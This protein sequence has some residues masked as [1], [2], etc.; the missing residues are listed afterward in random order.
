SRCCGEDEH[1]SAGRHE[2]IECRVELRNRVMV[3][4]VQNHR[5]ETTDRGHPER[6]QCCRLLGGGIRKEP[7]R[8][9]LRR[10]Q[11]QRRHLG[12]NAVS[13]QLGPP[14]GNLAYAP[15]DGRSSNFRAHANVLSW[16]TTRSASGSATVIEV[17]S[18]F[19]DSMTACAT[20]V[21]R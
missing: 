13:G 18:E 7:V 8:T 12:E 15:R 14:S 2:S 19:I 9:E 11:P 6:G 10:G 16:R 1:T 3:G 20:A 17:P 5:N 4:V 21:A